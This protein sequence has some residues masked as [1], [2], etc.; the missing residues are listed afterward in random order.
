[1]FDGT[2]AC[3]FPDPS[4]RG[5]NSTNGFI[6]KTRR[7]KST[8]R[9]HFSDVGSAR[10]LEPSSGPSRLLALRSHCRAWH[11]A[12]PARSALRPCATAKR[13]V[14]VR[15]RRDGV[16]RFLL[17]LGRMS[18]R[19]QAWVIA[20]AT[21]I[22][23]SIGCGRTEQDEPVGENAGTSGG[24]RSGMPGGGGSGGR[25][26]G[27]AGKGAAPAIQPGSGE[28]GGDEGAC[29]G[30]LNSVAAAWWTTCPPTLSAAKAWA[31]SCPALQPRPVTSITTCGLRVTIT[32]DY[33]THGKEC[34][35]DV[36][37][38]CNGE[39]RLAGAEA[40]DDVLTYC[41]GTANKITAGSTS[42]RCAGDAKQSRDVC[43]G[44]SPVEE[45]GGAAGAGGEQPVPEE[46]A[47][48]A[49][50]D[51]FG[52]SC[53]PCCPA[54]TPECADKPDGYPGYA[55]TPAPQSFCSCSCNGGQWT[56]GC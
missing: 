22:A 13:A 10:R 11:N 33:G 31:E 42:L 54:T 30:D 40:W 6:E 15:A 27:Q 5:G 24:E 8:L 3:S 14:L 39:A 46:P 12:V 47:L 32:L 55:C 52:N 49:C 25:A 44:A 43:V 48:T 26:P 21:V 23:L 2:T 56:C 34:Y 16:A 19:I 20:S 4:L 36:V 29:T 50:Y 38:P 45:A 28:T 37:P 41:N 35:Y 53:Q 7:A 18:N 9:G 1:M 17:D 51:A